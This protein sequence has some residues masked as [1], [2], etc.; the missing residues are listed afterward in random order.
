MSH[1]YTKFCVAT[2]DVLKKNSISK[3]IDTGR[4]IL[5]N[6]GICVNKFVL[7]SL[8]YSCAVNREVFGGTMSAWSVNPNF[9]IK[10]N[11]I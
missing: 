8:N 9:T 6:V 11:F 2:E 7:N 5:W 3:W 1:R 4:E 10:L